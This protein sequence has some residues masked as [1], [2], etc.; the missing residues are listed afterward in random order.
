MLFNSIEFLLFLPI[1]FLLYWFVFRQRRWQ[2][3][4]VV[5]A[6][7]IFYG[8]W[9]WR[10]LLLIV[11]TSVCSY[12]SG[13]LLEKNEGKRCVQKGISAA[14]IVVNLAVLGFFKYFN[15]F[16]DNLDSLVNAL[17]GYELGWVTLKI[18]L[19]VG[20]SFYTFQALSYSI[21]VYKHS[22]KATHDPIE[23]FA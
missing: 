15:F 4:L 2:N 6:S 20:I 9:D 22:I 16:V 1:V 7:Y 8:W 10:F 18:I 5:V 11:F 12:A 23:F 19:P 14:N 21:D 13:L 17:F 3:L